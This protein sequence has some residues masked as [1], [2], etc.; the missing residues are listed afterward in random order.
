MRTNDATCV[1]SGLKF[2]VMLVNQESVSNSL[3]PQFDSVQVID[4]RVA[5]KKKN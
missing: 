3:T 5:N 1:I 2:D 4:N